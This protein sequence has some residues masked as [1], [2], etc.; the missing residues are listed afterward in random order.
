M[1]LGQE[2][3]MMAPEELIA[4]AKQV[5]DEIEAGGDRAFKTFIKVARKANDAYGAARLKEW[6]EAVFFELREEDQVDL[7]VVLLK[8]FL[9]NAS[10]EARAQQ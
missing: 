3:S 7:L 10:A 1:L 5:G 2:T 9:D 6:L 4:Y 8:V